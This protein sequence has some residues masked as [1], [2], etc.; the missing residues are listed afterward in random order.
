[1]HGRL[2]RLAFRAEL[3]ADAAA[4]WA[5]I[6]AFDSLPRWHPL[7]AECTLERGTDG[8]IVRRTRLHD[9]TL[10]RNGLVAH[11]EAGRSY[12]YDYVEGPLTVENYR[13]TLSVGDAGTGR[14]RVEWISEFEAD[15][16]AADVMRAKVESLIAP[17]VANLKKVF[18]D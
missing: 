9:G 7:V 14:S 10:I 18:G 6:G 8:T 12:T 5:L 15:A 2:H 3:G 1:M 11:D 17:G 4:V 16:G 13:A